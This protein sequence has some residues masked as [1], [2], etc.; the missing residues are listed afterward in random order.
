MKNIAIISLLFCTGC[1]NA[2]IKPIIRGTSVLM[3]VEKDSTILAADSRSTMIFL[4]HREHTDTTHKIFKI[5]DYFFMTAGLAVI[6][7]ESI[8]SFLKNKLNINSNIS[9]VSKKSSN[10]FSLAIQSYYNSLPLIQRKALFKSDAI[11]N[12]FSL[13]IV[14]YVGTDVYTASVELATHINRNYVLTL[15]KYPVEIHKNNFSFVMGGHTDFIKRMLSSS[16]MP[17]SH[18]N[19]LIALIKYQAK[20]DV[21][22][23]STVNYVIIKPNSYRF[24]TN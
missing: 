4:D 24:G 5:G 17:M 18:L 6:G 13:M 20:Y 23:D 12:D 1:Y 22:V 14:K 9:N 11:R 21:E 8:Q 3:L 15:E 7:N 19:G 16:P 10:D 2:H